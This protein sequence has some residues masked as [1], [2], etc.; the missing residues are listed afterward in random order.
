MTAKKKTAKKP[1]AKKQAK[2]SGKTP[3]KQSAI[4]GTKPKRDPKLEELAETYEEKR[5]ERI[6][7]GKEESTA[8]AELTKYLEAK[9]ITTYFDGEL[10]VT[11]TTKDP[12]PSVKVKRV[13]S[14]EEAAE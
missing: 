5:D 7:W 12:T 14:H 9:G 3:A 11:L 1:A 10:E 4:P 6:A 2:K 8:K 13:E